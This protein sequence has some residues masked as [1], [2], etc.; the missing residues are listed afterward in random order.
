M[1]SSRAS[2]SSP[3]PEIV[4][5]KA[6][7]S[8][9][10]TKKSK[11]VHHAAEPEKHGRNEGEDASLAYK[12]PEGYVLMKHT[13]EETAFDWDAINNDDNLEL[14]VVRIP[15]GLKP[16]H[17][18]SV[19]L[20]APSS[21]S[22]TARIGSV[23]RKSAAYDVWSLGDDNDN[24]SA[25]AVGG[26]ELRAVS[27]LLPRRKKNGKLYQAPHAIA[28][29]LVISARP[30]LPTPPA[31]SPESSPVVHQN[32]PRPRHPPE[33]LKHRFAP[34]GSLAPIEDAAKME[35]DPA[36]STQ[37]PSKP[38]KSS[39]TEAAEGSKKKRKGDAGSPKKTKKAKTAA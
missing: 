8:K 7:K 9:F 16:K 30:T 34:L 12:P 3:E 35:V 26:D 14:W 37:T 2:F 21:T 5:A 19:K 28:R 6:K 36:P 20:D 18:E 32:P 38:S 24:P 23:D 11:H 1:S 31:S 25:E 29:R 33:L 4:P 39:K 27:C 17:L 22:K 13:A 10:K 15:D